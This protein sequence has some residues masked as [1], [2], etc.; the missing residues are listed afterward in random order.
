MP[1]MTARSEIS[2][3][4][5]NSYLESN[6][7]TAGKSADIDIVNLTPRAAFEELTKEPGRGI[8]RSGLRGKFEPRGVTVNGDDSDDSRDATYGFINRQLK[9]EPYF[10][11]QKFVTGVVHPCSIGKI[12]PRNT[13]ARGII[14]HG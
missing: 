8:P 14:I 11:E 10:L 13:T 1:D 7:S 4:I 5:K 6:A 9:S 3:M 12:R 2:V